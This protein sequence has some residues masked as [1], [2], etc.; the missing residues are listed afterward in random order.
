MKY[1][2][3]FYEKT[4]TV[5][6]VLPFRLDLTVW[7]LRRRQKN[8]IDSWDGATYSRVFVVN[9]VA[10]QSQVT[11][12]NDA[13]TVKVKSSNLHKDTQLIV[14]DKLKKMLG[15]D[16]NVE[17]FY[18]LSKRDKHL[19]PLAQSFI[20]VKPPRFPSF[21]EALLNAVACQQVTL[22]LGILL[23]N[24][25]AENYGQKFEDTE[26]IQY[27]FPRP[28]DLEAVSEE[29]IKKLGFSYQKA[30]VI[31][32]LVQTIL[33]N[34]AVFSHLEN[35]TNEE[36][37]I[38]LSNLRGIGRWSS[39]YILLRGLGRLN[40]FPGDDVGAQKNLQQL[41]GLEKRPGYEEIKQLIAKWQPYA[42][43]V[44]FHLL[45]EKLHKKK[46]NI[47]KGGNPYE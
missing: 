11:Q 36:I 23:L 39:E 15:L 13:L 31:K 9:N 20:G 2:H 16:I 8:A 30:H 42:G 6:P 10:S 37:I 34:N 26:G 19:Q 28:E 46:I 29:K 41:F 22:D 1:E 21:F 7:A 43:M 25:L 35:M 27:A 24:R 33:S 17:E 4:I 3:M 12:I 40:V 18:K 45:L 5:S 32:D 38:F 47:K 14:T 44:Y